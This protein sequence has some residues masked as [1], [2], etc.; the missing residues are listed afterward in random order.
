MTE[1]SSSDVKAEVAAVEAIWPLYCAAMI[2]GDMDRWIS[3]WVDAGVQMPPEAPAICGTQNIRKAN[4]PLLDLYAWDIS[5][6]PDETQVVGAWA[7]PRGNY[8]WAWTPKTGGE[9]WPARANS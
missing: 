2:D 4:Q 7:F 9:K 3:L 1:F 5:I 6:Y 8:Y